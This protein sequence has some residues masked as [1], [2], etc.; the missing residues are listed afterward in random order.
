MLQIR[1]VDEVTVDVGRDDVNRTSRTQRAVWFQCWQNSGEAHAFL[2]EELVERI[3][4]RDADR[5]T[6]RML[7][8]EELVFLA[9]LQRFAFLIDGLVGQTEI[10]ADDLRPGGDQH[11]RS[12]RLLA[13]IVMH[14]EANQTSARQWVTVFGSAQLSDT[15]IRGKGTERVVVVCNS[16]QRV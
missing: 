16:L 8:E 3:V 14:D 9:A 15:L 2:V 7:L 4:F 13:Q 1:T 12:D 6:G 5:S 11:G 10:V